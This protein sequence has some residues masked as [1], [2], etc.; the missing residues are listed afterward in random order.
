MIAEVDARIRAA[1][2]PA[3]LGP[4]PRALRYLGV[5]GRVESATT[6]FLAFGDGARPVL[7]IKVHREAEAGPRVHG[8]A[9]ILAALARRPGIAGSVP[10]V[11]LADRVGAAWMIVQTVLDGA[12][13]AGTDDD[14][15][16]A[17]AW[18]ERLHA[19][20]RRESEDALRGRVAEALSE[21]DRSFDL[22]ARERR[23]LGSLDVERA[24]RCGAF[25][26]H[27]DFAPHNILRTER[28]LNVIDWSD[29]TIAGAALNDALLFLV[30]STVLRTRRRG[31]MAELTAAFAH[32]FLDDGPARDRVRA[33]LRQHAR[34]TGVDATAIDAL[35]GV[36]LAT[37]AAAEAVRIRRAHARGSWSLFTLE[38]AAAEGI[39]PDRLV[40]AQPWIRFIRLVADR[41][42][43]TLA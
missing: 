5:A 22:S 7:A 33:L 37:T 32:S 42:G 19:A 3:L 30:T 11:L 16:S 29:A 1:W 18:L 41:G 12:P 20:D 28:S 23:Y 10:R 6:T 2:Q 17:I 34:A 24:V 43:T 35:F 14:A 31:G 38:T 13:M 40:E 21:I 25:L 4:P 15:S 27:G 39:G 26:Q 8:E 9:A 36:F